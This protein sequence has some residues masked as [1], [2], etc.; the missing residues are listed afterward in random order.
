MGIR[1]DSKT[2]ELQLQIRKAED[3]RELF[4]HS[5]LLE[6]SLPQTI[7]GGIGQS[8]MCM[9]LLRKR[10]IGEVQVSVWPEAIKAELATSGIELL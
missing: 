3:R 5:H 7:G 8:R 9:F 2:L 6:G 4:Y 1:V 10:H